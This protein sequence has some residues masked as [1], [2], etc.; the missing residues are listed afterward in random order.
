[1]GRGDWLLVGAFAALALIE[2]VATPDRPGQPFVTVLAMALMPVLLWR[3]TQPLLTCLVGF[4]AAAV[5]SLIQLATGSDDLG[6][7]SMMVIL[8]LLYSLVRWGSGKEIA[9]GLPFVAA[10]VALGMVVAQPDW[11][12]IIGGSLFVLLFIALAAVFRYRA[13]LA[14]RQHREIRNQERLALARDLHDTVAHHVSA[15]AVQAQAGRVVAAAQ[16][17]RAVEILA[18]I[19]SEAS[20]TLTEMRG[21]VQVLRLDTNDAYSPQPGVADLP[22]LAR[23]DTTPTVGVTLSGS[24]S[25]LPQ[26]V[27]IAVYRLAQESLTNAL[28]HA[29]SASRITIEVCRVAGD[30]SLRVTDD[31]LALSGATAGQGFGL[32]GMTERAN[33]LGGSLSAGPGPEGGWVVDV[34]L[35]VEVSA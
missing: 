30:V 20:R 8:L 18:A 3:R 15:I 22:A 34:V 19:E 7:T 35:P 28:R 24:L 12:T 14:H 5:L 10:V 17:E 26:P 9:L 29:R 25:D 2:G 31:G 11:A 33:L 6:L 21:V 23:T 13:D 1:M 16:P 27:D 4:G 32:M